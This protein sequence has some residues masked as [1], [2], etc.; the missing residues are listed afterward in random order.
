MD[1][2]TVGSSLYDC[3]CP[4]SACLRFCSFFLFMLFP[5]RLLLLLFRSAFCYGSQDKPSVKHVTVLGGGFV[6]CE[7]ALALAKR[8]RGRG[9]VVSHVSDASGGTRNALVCILIVHYD[10]CFALE[11][12]FV[13][14]V[15]VV[16]VVVVVGGGG[17][18][19]VGLGL[20]VGVVVVVVVFSSDYVICVWCYS[21]AR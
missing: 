14:V 12:M 7:V 3:R 5:S 1:G 4:L 13:A 16:V 19:G 21:P 20:G 6:G 15:V 9:M 10:T 17:G 2:L 18:V 11:L 8:G